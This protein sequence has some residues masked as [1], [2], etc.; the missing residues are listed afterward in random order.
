MTEIATRM[1]AL[2]R[3]PRFRLAISSS[4]ENFF[5]SCAHYD[6]YTNFRYFPDEACPLDCV[7]TDRSED[8]EELTY[9]MQWECDDCNGESRC[10]NDWFHGNQYY[11][12]YCDVFDSWYDCEFNGNCDNST[13][14]S[15]DD[16]SDDE[17]E[18]IEWCNWGT[19]C[20]DVP[21]DWQSCS[22]DPCFWTCTYEEINCTATWVD[23]TGTE[24]YGT[25]WDMACARGNEGDEQYCTDS[26]D[27]STDDGSTEE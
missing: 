20:Q 22:Y 6:D 18:M 9:L 27:D 21:E 10:A 23:E 12:D 3:D 26:G 19:P 25:C 24:N 14:D 17:C 5:A 2:R 8:F 15:S 16:G 7:D 1:M 11:F 4:A 13:D